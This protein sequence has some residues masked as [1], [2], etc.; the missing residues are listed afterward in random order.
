MDK[1]RSIAEFN[2]NFFR[3]EGGNNQ[4]DYIMLS[5]NFGNFAVPFK[6]PVQ[7]KTF[8]KGFIL[9]LLHLNCGAAEFPF[10]EEKCSLQ[11]TASVLFFEREK[12]VR[13]WGRTFLIFCIW[14]FFVFK[15]CF[16][17]LFL[18]GKNLKL[19]STF[20]LS[21]LLNLILHFVFSMMMFFTFISKWVLLVQLNTPFCK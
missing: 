1:L 2:G 9:L 20:K 12:H 3:G 4:L 14:I 17:C 7:Q 10:Q 15:S 19:L 8:S 18:D 16:A 21:D 13:S 11:C 6:S 5:E